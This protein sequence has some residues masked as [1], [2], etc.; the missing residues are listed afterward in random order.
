MKKLITSFLFLTVSIISIAQT[1][2]DDYYGAPEKQKLL[3]KD[4]VSASITAGTGVN[5]SSNTKSTSFTTFIAPKISYQL[6]Q[7]FKLNVG[8]MHYSASPN[9]VLYMNRNEAIFNSS[10]KNI[11]GNLV[12]VGGDYQ[13]NKRIILSGA[14]MMNA[15]GLSDKQKDYKAASFGVDYK[16][17]EHSSIKFE[18]TISTGNNPNYYNNPFPNSGSNSFGT[19]FSNEMNNSTFR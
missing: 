15:N 7:K 3:S 8:L 11:S 6:S 5:F 12:F 17:S 4:R 1:S 18:T 16:V 2:N 14:V 13:L 9:S 10:N 19:G